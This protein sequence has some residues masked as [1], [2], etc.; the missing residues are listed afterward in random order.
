MKQVTVLE[1][2]WKSGIT[3]QSDFYRKNS[4]AVALCASLG[5]IS[6]IDH[7]GDYG[8]VWRITPVGLQQLHSE[9]EDSKYD[10][11]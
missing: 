8:N 2:A 7:E 11:Q 4:L 1:R 6:T 10:T 9:T 3:L 5:H